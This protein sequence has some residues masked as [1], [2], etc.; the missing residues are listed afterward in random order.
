M[1]P[2]RHIHILPSYHSKTAVIK[3]DVAPELKDAEFYIYKKLDGGQEWVLLN[4]EPVYGTIYL[5]TDFYSKNKLDNPHYK[6]L[7]LLN[8]KEYISDQ[9]ALF[10][11]L[12]RREFGIIKK[13]IITKFLQAKHDGI[14]VLYYPAIKNGK[15][16][17]NLDPITGQRISVSCQNED[18]DT[19]DYGTYYQGGYCAPFITFIRL[20]G[21]NLQRTSLTEVGKWDESVQ[22]VE[23]LPYPPVRSGDMIVDVVTDKRWIINDSIKPQEFKGIPVSYITTM[24]LQPRNEQCYGV[25]IPDNYYDMGKQLKLRLYI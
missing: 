22:N 20:L 8:D 19:N 1:I 24:S 18:Q 15:V 7:A 12:R 16:S 23:M 5:D 11:N 13:I 10:S 3:W 2:F 25:P 4:T 9:V 21:S 14:P 17:V 6:L